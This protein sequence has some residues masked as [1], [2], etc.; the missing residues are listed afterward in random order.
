MAPM[1]FHGRLGRYSNRAPIIIGTSNILVRPWK[2]IGRFCSS[3]TLF[4]C[5]Y[6]PWTI[7]PRSY[8]DLDWPRDSTLFQSHINGAELDYQRPKL[9]I[10]CSQARWSTTKQVNQC[11]VL[12]WQNSCEQKYKMTA[13]S[14]HAW[15]D[16]DARYYGI[17]ADF[18]CG[19][20]L[21]WCSHWI[22]LHWPPQLASYIWSYLVLL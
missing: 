21:V 12:R 2:K 14:V 17:H 5:S 3:V 7:G 4:Y 8:N 19:S 10:A 22:L 16:A 9:A 1:D 18:R 20:T 11:S 6:S 13:L 15:C